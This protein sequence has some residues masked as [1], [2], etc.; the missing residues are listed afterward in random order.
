VLLELL[1]SKLVG[2]NAVHSGPSDLAFLLIFSTDQ[3]EVL[4]LIFFGVNT[5]GN[6]GPGSGEGLELCGYPLCLLDDT[7]TL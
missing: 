5:G 7:A 6:G 4:D 2:G 1:R 3:T